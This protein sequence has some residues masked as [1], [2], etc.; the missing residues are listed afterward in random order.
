VVA[1]IERPLMAAARGVFDGTRWRAAGP[2]L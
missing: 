1:F 2:W